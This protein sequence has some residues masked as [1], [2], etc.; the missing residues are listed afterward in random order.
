MKA[1]LRKMMLWVIRILRAPLTATSDH[2]KHLQEQKSVGMSGE[3]ETFL[4]D[5]TKIE[6][7]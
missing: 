2:E 5:L 7:E 4:G 1:L 6:A 3:K